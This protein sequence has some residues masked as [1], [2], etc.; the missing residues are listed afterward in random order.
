[1][2]GMPLLC[3]FDAAAEFADKLLKLFSYSAGCDADFVI[4]KSRTNSL[5]GFGWETLIAH[6]AEFKLSI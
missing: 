1:M 3:Y 2:F 4:S 6:N 5:V